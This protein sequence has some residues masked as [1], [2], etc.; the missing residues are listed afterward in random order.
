MCTQS[1]THSLTQLMWCP[2]TEAL[3]LRNIMRRGL[4]NVLQFMLFYI[5]FWVNK[6]SKNTAQTGMRRYFSFRS[7]AVRCG[8]KRY[9]VTSFVH[10]L[11]SLATASTSSCFSSWVHST[12]GRRTAVVPVALLEVALCLQQRGGFITWATSSLDFSL[13]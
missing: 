3:T 8:W 1:I 6:E 5:C 2:G 13:V 11:P 10:F 7:P 9:V 4:K 12:R